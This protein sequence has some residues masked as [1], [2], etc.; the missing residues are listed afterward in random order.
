MQYKFQ[1][2]QVKEMKLS[3]WKSATFNALFALAKI[4]DSIII[5]CAKINDNEIFL[6]SRSHKNGNDSRVFTMALYELYSGAAMS[7]AAKAEMCEKPQEAD[8]SR[9]L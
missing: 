9:H 1:A 6:I 4:Q 5:G 7:S 2:R 8:L 3:F